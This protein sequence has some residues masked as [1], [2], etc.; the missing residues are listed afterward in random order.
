VAADTALGVQKLIVAMR[1]AA[2]MLQSR[3]LIDDCAGPT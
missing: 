2:V 3:V 1:I